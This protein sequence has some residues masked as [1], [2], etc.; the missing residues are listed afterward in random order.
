MAHSTG[1]TEHPVLGEIEAFRTP[2]RLSGESS[3]LRRRAPLLGEHTDEVLA[4]LG[5][6]AQRIDELVAHG[7]VLR[8]DIPASPGPAAIA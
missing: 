1:R 6:S 8:P 5:Y 2:I 3:P 7:V 4:E